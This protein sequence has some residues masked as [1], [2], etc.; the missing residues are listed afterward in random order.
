MVSD[1]QTISLQFEHTVGIR[2]ILGLAM[3]WGLFSTSSR[4]QGNAPSLA[5]TLHAVNRQSID[6]PQ[7]T[8]PG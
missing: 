3:G 4:Y 1:S 2:V 7:R 6:G 5:Q 8:L